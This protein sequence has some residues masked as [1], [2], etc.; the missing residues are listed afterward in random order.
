M[1]LLQGLQGLPIDI[2]FGEL[3]K[4][5]YIA[6]HELEVEALAHRWI[7]VSEEG[8]VLV[9]PYGVGHAPSGI[10]AGPPWVGPNHFRMRELAWA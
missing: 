3:E 2:A 4:I 1:R 6:N 10:S 7:W 8:T 5:L 9:V